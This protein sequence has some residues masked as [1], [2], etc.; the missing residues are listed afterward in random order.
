MKIHIKVIPSSKVEQVQPALDGS[1][2]VW[3]QA[4]PVDGEANRALVRLLAKYYDVAKS[5]VKIVSGLTSRRKLVEV[6][7]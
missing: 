5:Q 2:K 3:L 7:N 6:D 4:K 1:L